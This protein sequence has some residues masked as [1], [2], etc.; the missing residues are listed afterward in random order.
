MRRSFFLAT[1]APLALA[2]CATTPAPSTAPDA[3]EV[4]EFSRRVATLASEEF[5][6]REPGTP[7]IE[8][9]AAFIEN[10]LA[11]I[12][13]EPFEGSWRLPFE[14]SGE[15]R[16]V[17]A[18][19][20][21]EAPGAAGQLELEEQFNP[22]GVSGDG[23]AEGTLAFVGYGIESGPD[24]YTSYA[25]GDD[26]TGKIAV[27]LRFEPITDA[28]TSRWSGDDTWTSASALRAKFASVAER[29]PEGIIFVAPP[30]VVDP[31]A[32]TL[33]T[34]R[35]TRIGERLDIPVVAAT[36]EAVA[37]LVQLSDHSGRSLSDLRTLADEGDAGVIDLSSGRVRLETSIAIEQVRT[38]NIAGVVPGRGDLADEWVVIGAHY[39][40][41]GL[42]SVG[43]SRAAR[44]IGKDIHP[45]ADDNA[46]GVA[47]VLQA[48]EELAR[49]YALLPPNA[50]ARSVLLLFF[51]AEE[52]GL[53]GSKAFVEEASIDAGRVTAMLNLD[54]IGRLRR[55]TLE[56]SGTGTA[57][58]FEDMLSALKDEHGLRID[59]TKS[60]VGPSDHASFYSAGIPVLA[61]FTGTHA[62]Y[63]TPDDTPDMVNPE[64]GARVADLVA[65]IAYE[66]ALRPDRLGYVET[67]APERSGPRRRSG[68]SLGFMP[69]S[70]DE[71]EP[72]VLIGDV[73]PGSQAEKAGLQKGDR[74]VGWNGEELANVFA[75]MQAL[76]GH[77]PGDRVMLTVERGE[78]ILG[79]PATLGSS[80]RT[81]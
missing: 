47:G 16:V 18:S 44:S 52:M 40:H 2:G 64:G 65:D 39:D 20:A 70:Y 79:M 14:V 56:V 11:G 4:D 49:E 13:A 25:A 69:G 48:G 66:L 72:G 62:E 26:L 12:G 55:D 68:V 63:H 10:E 21:Y 45:G 51:S 6:G 24:G 75:Y 80:D 57:E 27:L 61:F 7:G 23:V 5:A 59:A 17:S 34:A 15:L 43:R 60:G 8:L 54:M 30:G 22:L 58:A 81:R 67:K 3:S 78:E 77:K 38:D 19:F 50:D 36:T 74:I 32:V 33:P 9:A 46:S 53:L 28:G 29:N 37:R 71:S 35:S 1:L 31:R 76:G 41:L 42:G 73:L